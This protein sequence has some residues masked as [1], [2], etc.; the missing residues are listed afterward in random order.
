MVLDTGANVGKRLGTLFMGSVVDGVSTVL[1]DEKV[2]DA[3]FLGEI[4]TLRQLGDAILGRG[5]G[6][7]ASS[8]GCH[9]RV[10]KRAFGLAKGKVICADKLLYSA[11]PSSRLALLNESRATNPVRSG[12][13]VVGS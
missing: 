11:K 4:I 2:M 1:D 12:S 5:H 7:W 6:S 3:D 13:V 8:R 9:D 10:E